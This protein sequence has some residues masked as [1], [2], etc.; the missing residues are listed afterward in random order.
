MAEAEGSKGGAASTGMKHRWYDSSS[1]DEE[2]G[3]RPSKSRIGTIRLTT[4]TSC[5]TPG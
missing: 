2:D 5:P 1:S 4:H 3:D